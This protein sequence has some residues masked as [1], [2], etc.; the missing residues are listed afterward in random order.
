M[1]QFLRGVIIGGFALYLWY[2]IYPYVFRIFTYRPE[3]KK[4][5]REV[6]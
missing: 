3:D 1:I 2:M 4:N 6:W 5:K